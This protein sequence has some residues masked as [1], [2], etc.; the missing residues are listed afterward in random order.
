[1]VALAVMLAGSLLMAWI[2]FTVLHMNR[3]LTTQ[4]LARDRLA[5]QVQQ[6]G[7][8]PVAGPPGSRGEPGPSGAPGRDAPTPDMTAIARIAAGLVTPSPGPSG[9]PGS[10]GPSSTVAGPAGPSGLP[11]ADS[12]VPGPTGPAG[13][14]GASGSPPAG[15]TFTYQGVTY[16]C[17]PVAAFN[18]ASPQYQCTAA[19]PSPSPSPTPTIH[20]NRH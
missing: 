19:S 10:P 12:T 4:E 7:A 13:A 16:T 2:I 1:V 6:L 8:T 14:P 5:Q 20:G 15:W 18:P 9:P 11:G 17:T 3:E